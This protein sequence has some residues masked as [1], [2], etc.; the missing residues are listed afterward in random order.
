MIEEGVH[1]MIEVTATPREL[2]HRSAMN[3]MVDGVYLTPKNKS[4]R[5]II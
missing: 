5:G 4:I 1:Q 3:I 2:E